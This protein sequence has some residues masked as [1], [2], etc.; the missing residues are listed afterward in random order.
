VQQYSTHLHTNS[1]QNTDNGTYKT[2][3]KLIG[4]FRPC[5][6]FASYTLALAVQMRKKHGK[7]SFRVLKTSVRV[8]K[9]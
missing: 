2:I 8:V 5:P 7:T 6:V 1:T 3:K 9:T 4:K